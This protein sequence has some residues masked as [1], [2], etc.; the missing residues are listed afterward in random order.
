M[1]STLHTHN[2]KKE[3]KSYLQGVIPFHDLKISM[4]GFFGCVSMKYH[5][6]QL[7]IERSYAISLWYI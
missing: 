5:L 2:I 7:I 3:A 1:D 6:S 4:L